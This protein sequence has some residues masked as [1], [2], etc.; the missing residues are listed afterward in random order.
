[1]D[2]VI[3]DQ[4]GF[5][6]LASTNILDKHSLQNIKLGPDNRAIIYKASYKVPI[7]QHNI[8]TCSFFSVSFK[9][10]WKK[11]VHAVSKLI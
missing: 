7:A 4:I 10:F 1:M 6:W 9:Y 5:L 3:I 8:L 11:V 2:I